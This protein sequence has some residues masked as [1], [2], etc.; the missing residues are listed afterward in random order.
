MPH[1][2]D[3]FIARAHDR[4]VQNYHENSHPA[5][6]WWGC[7]AY[8]DASVIVGG[9]VGHFSWHA[10]RSDLCA[11]IAEVL[12]YITNTSGQH[13]AVAEVTTAITANMQHG[14][15][16][17]E[18]GI[19][20][21]NHILEHYSQIDWIGTFAELCNSDDE[22]CQRVRHWYRRRV[23]DDAPKASFDRHAPIHP[24]EIDEFRE[25]ISEYGL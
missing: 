1:N 2:F 10:N 19:E 7:F 16:S 24:D 5:A 14:V 3:V 20:R 22:F 21:L 12:P 18:N 13:G 6:E 23:D 17:D 4:F 9:G 8:N 11:F 15:I 25:A